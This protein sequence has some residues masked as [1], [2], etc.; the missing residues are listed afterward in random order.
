MLETYDVVIVGA[1]PA[2]CMCAFEA[3][4][5]VPSLQILLIDKTSFPRTKSCGGML[6]LDFVQIG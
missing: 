3:K 5:S 6:N 2:G 4:K 1:G